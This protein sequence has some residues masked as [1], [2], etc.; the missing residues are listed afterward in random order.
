MPT[1]P[2]GTPELCIAL[3][4]TR[5][6][7]IWQSVLT[8]LLWGK[9]SCKSVVGLFPPRSLNLNAEPRS[10]S[11]TV[12]NDFLQS[13][14]AILPHS[15]CLTFLFCGGNVAGQQAPGQCHAGVVLP[16]GWCMG[17]LQGTVRS[18]HFP[19]SVLSQGA[20]QCSRDIPA[21]WQ[22]ALGC[23]NLH[24]SWQGASVL[25]SIWPSFAKPKHTGD[26]GTSR[27]GISQC[28][29]MGADGTTFSSKAVPCTCCLLGQSLC[30]KHSVMSPKPRPQTQVGGEEENPHARKAR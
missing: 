2:W 1:F 4:R 17:L 25:K 24:S 14:W 23:F 3:C 12:M 30:F 8:A 16:F 20:V 27:P 5:Q 28:H 11:F 22:W 26:W 15:A 19:C 6:L 9:G 10:K 18:P 21:S 13:H 29:S 7:G